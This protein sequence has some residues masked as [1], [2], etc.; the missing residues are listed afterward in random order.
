MRTRQPPGRVLG[1]GV[2]MVCTVKRQLFGS[3][4]GA[5]TVHLRASKIQ[6]VQFNHIVRSPGGE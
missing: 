5:I 6:I 2:R 1:G 3:P 4:L